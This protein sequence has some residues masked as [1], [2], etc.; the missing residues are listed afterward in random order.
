MHGL[1]FVFLVILLLPC[2]LFSLHPKVW[3]ILAEASRCLIRADARKREEE[4]GRRGE[5]GDVVYNTQHGSSAH[6]PQ[7]QF[8]LILLF[9][10]FAHF[11]PVSSP[12]EPECITELWYKRNAATIV[13]SALVVLLVAKSIATISYCVLEEKNTTPRLN[14]NQLTFRLA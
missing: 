11:H 4:Q 1:V 2:L 9:F 10:I 14:V 12:P 5:E 3:L 6:E 8:Q 13:D 7:T